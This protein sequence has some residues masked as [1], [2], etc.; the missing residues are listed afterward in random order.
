MF[1]C[2]CVPIRHPLIHRKFSI[3]KRGTY[4]LL[5]AVISYQTLAAYYRLKHM[6]IHKSTT[7]AHTFVFYMI[8]TNI[9]N[10]YGFL[11][12]NHSAF[13]SC[14]R[15]YYGECNRLIRFTTYRK[16]YKKSYGLSNRGM[17]W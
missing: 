3:S 15:K 4:V 1:N 8:P 6:S 5:G 7:M 16:T 14:N 9:R 10:N 12:K 13:V 11:H 17:L 2:S